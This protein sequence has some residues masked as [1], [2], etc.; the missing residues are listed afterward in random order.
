M[1]NDILVVG[2]ISPETQEAVTGVVK[3]LE[4]AFNV[5]DPLALSEQFTHMTSWSNAMGTRLD[6]RE[7]IAEF[8]APAMKGFLRDSYARYDVVKLLEIA[9]DVIAVNVAQTPTDSS[10]DPVEGV[11]GAALYVIAK[12]ADGWKIVAG[13][14]TAVGAPPA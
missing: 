2:V 1:T 9:P 10:G 12:Q 13:Q 3:G 11:R 4:K 6:D 14:N 5:K 8:S 7:A